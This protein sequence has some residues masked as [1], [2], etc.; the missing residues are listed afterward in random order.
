M[1]KHYY[2]PAFH[3]IDMEGH[4]KAADDRLRNVASLGEAFIAIASVIDP[5]ND[6]HTFF[7]PPPRNVR[8]DYGYEERIVGD[9]CFVTA[10]RPG[11]AAGEKLVP[12]DEVM[13]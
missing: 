5:L 8:R 2:E 11:G 6:S 9:R 1:R 13:T 10:V 12:G 3:G 7:V 4:I